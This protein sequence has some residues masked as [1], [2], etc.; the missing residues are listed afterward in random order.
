[1]IKQMKQNKKENEKTQSSTIDDIVN[2]VSSLEITRKKEKNEK[3]E[4]F[5]KRGSSEI[6]KY[7]VLSKMQVYEL[8]AENS[9]YSKN[10]IAEFFHIFESFVKNLSDKS[11]EES[12]NYYFPFLDS[13]FK[14]DFYETRSVRNPKSGDNFMCNDKVQCSLKSK[15]KD[16]T[17]MR[18]ILNSNI[19][20]ILNR[21]LMDEDK[22]EYVIRYDE[23]KKRYCLDSKI[24]TELLDSYNIKEEHDRY[25]INVKT[26][27]K[28]Y[29]LFIYKANIN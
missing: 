25:V 28:L 8:M 14:I 17:E 22:N 12:T 2:L 6:V 11:L 26:Q 15:R 5:L 9:K 13:K 3:N 1:M 7:K 27:F 19:S 10:D 21:L 29:D 24:K 16:E 18:N 20:Q 23:N 4:K